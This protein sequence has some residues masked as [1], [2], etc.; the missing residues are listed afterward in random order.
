MRALKTK[1]SALAKEIGS[2][3]SSSVINSCDVDA[4][5]NGLLGLYRHGR[6][7]F[8]DEVDGP[9]TAAAWSA[10]YKRP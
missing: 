8:N 3:C 5:P 10:R 6:R 4:A 2:I 1:V 9:E 7:A